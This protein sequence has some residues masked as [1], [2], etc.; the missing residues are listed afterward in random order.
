MSVHVGDWIREVLS[1][2][3]LWDITVDS[4]DLALGIALANVSKLIRNYGVITVVRA[5]KSY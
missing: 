4:L 3:S 2:L 5:K 1:S